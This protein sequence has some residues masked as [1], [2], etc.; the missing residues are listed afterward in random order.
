[1]REKRVREKR[2]REKRV[3]EK[4][5]RE[6]RK[7]ENSKATIAV[8]LNKSCFNISISFFNE[9]CLNLSSLLEEG[10]S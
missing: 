9:F 10:K 5:A 6:K 2:V 7:K 3:R 8:S 1:M 4:R